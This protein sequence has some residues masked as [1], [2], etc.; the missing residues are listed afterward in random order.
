MTHQFFKFIARN[1]LV[2]F[3]ILAASF[4]YNKLI[5]I[6]EAIFF[7]IDSIARILAKGHHFET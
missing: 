1:K 4:H 5:S 2:N 6:P 3:D 7:R